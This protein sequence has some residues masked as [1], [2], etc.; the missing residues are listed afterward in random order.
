MADWQDIETA[1]QTGVDILG[2]EGTLVFVM[3]W[4]RDNHPDGGWIL[5]AAGGNALSGD[6]G[7]SIRYVEAGGWHGP[8]RPT[9][10]MPLPEP[11]K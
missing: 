10:W 5:Q 8:E 9:H 7:E 1:P 2:T 6:I 3:A 4:R 11:P